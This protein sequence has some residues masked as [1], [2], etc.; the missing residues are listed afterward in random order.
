M[1]KIIA[2]GMASIMMIAGLT[3]C[4]KAKSD[5]LLDIDYTDYVK[6]CDYKGVET[7]KVVFEVTEE[8][9][10]EE[11][12]YTLYEYVTYDPITDRG[13]KEGDYV[14][15]SYT[16]TIDGQVN[17]DYSGDEEEV[18]IG[19]GYIY[20][21]LEDALI[22]MK[23]GDTKEV[24]VTFTEEYV[25]ESMVGKVATIDVTMGDITIE[26]LPEYNLDFVKENTEFET[27][28]E[29]EASVKESLEAYKKDEYK[30]YAVEELFNYVLENSEFDGYPEELYQK[31]EEMYDSNNEY[32]ASMYGME[33]EEFLEMF[34][35]DEETKKE[36]V[37]YSINYELVIGAIAQEEGIDCSK[38]EVEEYIEELYPDYDYDSAEEFLEDY[39]EEEVGYDL[40]YQKV[41]D[42]LYENAT[43]VEI[44]EEDYLAEQEQ[45]YY[46][47]EA[48]D[49]TEEDTEE[50]SVDSQEVLDALEDAVEDAAEGADATEEVATTEVEEES[51]TAEANTEEE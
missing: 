46:D 48:E 50:V 7:T 26:V 51:G 19:E 43:F 4:N 22:G 12:D 8:D 40:L 18:Y 17:E 2:M 24:E 27:M 15:I 38:K 29:Y 28:E 30:Y 32:Y 37:E 5:Y 3:G 21:E 25:E 23:T 31:C 6:L 39:S 41:C 34:G 13:A 9:V 1:K 45:Y 10:Q 35:I 44:S 49:T 20:P 42:F 36:E 47:E 14:V 11:I 33:L 16:T